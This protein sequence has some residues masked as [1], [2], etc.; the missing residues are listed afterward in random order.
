[1][2]GDCQ[3]FTSKMSKNVNIQDFANIKQFANNVCDSG[4]QNNS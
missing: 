1:M 4:T 2:I 3:A